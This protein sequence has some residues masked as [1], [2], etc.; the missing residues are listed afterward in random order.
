M[1]KKILLTLVVAA[2]A[3]YA[4]ACGSNNDTSST[5]NNSQISSST[6]EKGE[7]NDETNSEIDGYRYA[8]FD[9]Y[10]SYAE[11]N[12][13][14]DTP[15]YIKGVVK[16]VSEHEDI[17]TLSVVS[18]DGGKWLVIFAGVECTDEVKEIFDEKDVTCFGVY[19]GFSDVFQMPAIFADKVKVGINTYN[20][21][22]LIALSEPSESTNKRATETPTKKAT[23][24]PKA[25]PTEKEKI[26]NNT[27]AHGFWANGSGDY[28]AE[29]LK[30]TKYAVLHIKH[31]G[32]SNF[33]VTSYNGDSYDDLLVNEIG[34]YEGDV[35]IEHSGDFSLEIKAGGNWNITSSGL[36]IDDTTSFS[37]SG[38]GVTGITS[39]DGGSWQ[40]T[41]NNASSNF[42]VTQ[43]G[44]DSGYMD[45]LV[46]E[47]G[48]YSGVV[49]SELGDDI[50][51]SVKSDGNW[52]IEKQ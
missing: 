37:G 34:D 52:T 40:I 8:D 39:Y 28:V 49:K 17:C 45:L 19:Q 1:K 38:D 5:E 10:N 7:K 3:I 29:G 13:L 32:D 41:N 44:L 12:G 42:Q 11:N 14:G 9:K 27:S 35:L 33:Q 36:S 26:T 31:T 43:Y 25:P 2:L 51:F 46:N 16:S 24:S 22:D 23:E 18:E 6:L 48:N 4:T 21:T 50:F 30:V 47:I 15:V 20:T